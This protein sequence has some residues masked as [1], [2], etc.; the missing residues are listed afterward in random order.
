M[1]ELKRVKIQSILESQ[2]PEFLNEESPLFKSF[3]ESYYLSQEYPTGISDLAAN[4]S[5]FKNIS[6]YNDNTFFSAFYPSVLTQK[7][8]AF[9]DEINV[10]HTIGFPEKYGLIKIGDEIITYTSKT[11]N[12]FIGCYRGFSGIHD[13]KK[14]LSSTINF[15]KT[16]ASEHVPTFLIL[17]VSR[18]NLTWRISLVDPVSVAVGEVITFLDPTNPEDVPY[19]ASVTNV[20]SSQL[21]EVETPYNIESKKVLLKTIV[22]ENLSLVFYQE[23]FKKFKAQFLP[24]FEN[25]NFVPQVKIRN[26]L[27][28]ANDFYITKGTDTSF[29]LLFK[30]LYNKD[31]SVIKP[32]EYLLR[33]SDNNYFV[34]RNIL[35]EQ[36]TDGDP[37]EARGKTLFQ[38]LS[39]GIVA[40][41]SIYSIEYRPFNNKNLY[42]IYL[43][44][45]SFDNNYISTKKTNISKS[46]SAGSDSIFVDSTIGFPQSGKL[47]IK[48]KNLT[49]PI[50]INYEDKTN[51]Q[52]LGVS[53]IIANLDFNDE[54]YEENFVYC[55]LDDGS[56]LEFRLINIIGD[57]D[58]DNTSNM[59]VDDKIKLSSFGIEISDQPEFN[60]WIYN[61]PTVHRIKNV[62]LSGSTTGDVWTVELYDNVKFFIGETIQL[63]NSEDPDDIIR[64]AEI[65][66][67]LSEN[68][69][70]VYSPFSLST[71]KD[72]HRIIKTATNNNEWD[73]S[74][75]PIGI[76]NTYI[77]S[78]NNNF[79]VTSSGIPNYKIFAKEQK[80]NVTPGLGI[81]KTDILNTDI[82]HKFY[83]GEK[84]Y[85]VPT[86]L[87][88]IST[89]IY[90]LTTVGDVEDSKQIKLSLS[91]SDLYT[92]KYLN[93][94]KGNNTGFFVKLDYENK[95][96]KNQK[97][98]KK[99]NYKKNQ[100]NLNDSGDK[101]TNNKK[102]GI[103]V[104]GVEL[105]SPTLFDENIYY[106]KLDLIIVTDNGT[107]YD[108]I[109]PP[110]IE[111]S[112]VSGSGAKAYPIISG[113]L[114]RVRIINPGIGYQVKPKITV[115]G[116]NG[117][118]AVVEPNFVR[119]QIVS[120]F[121]GDG[122]GVNPTT[123]TLTFFNNHNFDDGEPVIYNANFNSNIFPLKDNAIYYVGVVNE[124][125]LRLYE[126]VENA[127]SKENQI[128]LVGISSGFHYLKSVKSKN[129]ITKLTIKNKGEGYS[130]RFV[131]VP[132]ILSFDNATNG[133]NSFDNYIFA[134]NHKF[135]NKDIV[136]YST[137]GTT[138][139]G[140]STS[141]NY[142]VTTIDENKF[143]VSFA[144]TTTSID[145]SDFT[146]K[147][148][149]KFDSL[150]SGEHIFSYPPIQLNIETLSGVGATT[151]ISPEFELVFTGSI[152]NVFLEDSGVGYGVSNII[153]FHRRPDIRIKPIASEALL[154][155]IVVNGSIV[156][157]QF[158]TYGKGYDKGI[159]IEVY[160]KGKF[161][162]IRPIVDQLGRITA[163]NIANGGVGYEQ[164]D[165][166]LKVV[167]RGINAKFLGN[168]FE[169]KINQVEKNKGLSLSQ[170]E[171]VI[172][173]SLS[174][175]LGL[176]YI[177]FYSPKAFR[178]TINDHIDSSNRE[179]SNNTHSPIIGWA[180]DG[181]PI[182]GPYG[183]VGADIRRIRSSYYKNVETNKSLRPDFDDGFFVQDYIFDK[184]I[185]DLDEYNGRYCKTPEYPNG[186]YAYFA[187][188]NTAAISK[189]E[190]PYIVGEEF[191][192]VVIQENIT[193]SFSQD[194][195]ISNK[196][197]IRNIG[198]YYINSSYSRYDLI[199]STDEK[200]KQEFIVSQ[201]LKSSVEDILVYSPGKDYKV[202]DDVIFDNN[203][204]GG[205]GI[206]A[207]VSK[208]RG[209]EI[210]N[211][212]VG[213][214]TFSEV[215]F[216]TSGSNVVGICDR[217]HNFNV[218]DDV[219]ISSISNPK[220]S[221]FE[222]IKKIITKEKTVG[223]TSDIDI[224]A[225][226]GETTNIFVNDYTGFEV[227]DYI[228]IGSEV[229][230]ITNIDQSNFKFTVNRLENT[231]IH[232]VGIDSVKLLPK[233]FYFVE[234]NL[235]TYV[236]PN[237][238]AYFNPKTLIGF[239]T[240]PAVYNL[241]SVESVNV[242]E[243]SI[244]IPNHS[245]YTGQ[246]VTYNVGIGGTGIIVS[247]TPNVANS[248]VL[249][250]N[251]TLYVINKGKNFIGISTLGFT[252]TTGIGSTLNSLYIY[253]DV[254]VTGFAHSLSTTFPEVYGKVENYSLELITSENH[255]LNNNSR[256]NFNILPKLTETIYIRY[257]S[258]LRK[259]TTEILN[260]DTTVSVSTETSRIYLPNNKFN[261]GDKVV[262][263]DNGNGSIGGLNNNQPYYVI[264]QDPDYIRLSN[265]FSD[266][267]NGIGITFTSQG[268]S[269]NGLALINPL[270]YGTKGNILIFDLSDISLSGMDLKLYKDGNISVQIESYKYKRNGIDA[271]SLGAKL[272]LDTNDPEFSNTL[273]YNLIPLSPS[274][275]EK[276]QV[277]ID[278]EVLGY[279]KISLQESNLNDEYRI[280]KTSDN[281]F[282]FNLRK[283]PER[284]TYDSNVGLSSIY[285]ETDDKNATGPISKIKLN[286][287]GKNYKKV[288][289]IVNIRSESGTGG[290]LKCIS[291]KIG[292]INYIERVK[293]G[294]DYP[295]DKTLKPVLSVPTICQI[296]GISRLDKVKVI[297]GG[298]KY[299]IPPKLKVIGNDDVIL[300]PIIQG[301]SIS[302][303]IIEKNT[304]N[305]SRPLPI[306]PIKNS[307][308]YDIDDITYNPATKDVT[309]ELINSDNQLYPLITNQFGS[310]SIDFPFKVG[311]KIFVENCRITDT[312]KLNYNSSNYGYRFFTVTGISTSNF[313]VTYNM[314]GF[315]S[316]LGEYNTDFNYGSVV[317]K[318]DM[319]E[320]EMILVDDL[321]YNS[322]EVVIG[323]NQDGVETFSARVM[324]NGWDNSI[325]QLRLNDSKGELKVGD[326]LS[327]TRSGLNG[328]VE[329]IN[330]FNL[331]ANLDVSREKINSFGDRVGFLNDYQQRISDNDY[332]QK[333]SYSIKSDVN[334][335]TWK[336]AIKSLVHPAGFK[337]FSDLDV[338]QKAS[339]NMKVGVGDS[340]LNTSVNID[341]Y[342]SMYS[343]SNFSMVLEDDQLEDGSIERVFF[344]EGVNLKSYLLSK[345]NKVLRIDDISDQFTGFTTTMGGSIVGISTFKLKNKG[346]PLFYREFSGIST[347]VVNLT[348]N[349]FNL[350]NHNFQSG[351]KLFYGV[352]IQTND[353]SA[354]ANNIVDASFSYPS[355]STSFDS[356][357]LSFDST[358]DTM[359]SN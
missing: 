2:I 153:N 113:S 134:L 240:Q 225:V 295:T 227:D 102:V 202:G 52:F 200:Y 138:I 84:I 258:V 282:K 43:D 39:S 16:S 333:F 129:T 193:P 15:S 345:T 211:I 199:E 212:N 127:Y 234:Q 310:S 353:L 167:R 55:Y 332:Y 288:P 312:T 277:S 30:V 195:D 135:K 128:N 32:Q 50:V 74:D 8:L 21:I 259:S 254:S 356:Q 44:S 264:K 109:N 178:Y 160:G 260:F 119:S 143:Y 176:Q 63:S 4:L 207:A 144:G 13:I 64:Q 26:I 122:L 10:L 278:K 334:Y 121:K 142:I 79:Y 1:S 301:N 346:I 132:S 17:N 124:K 320:F 281:I 292:K 115:I 318:K 106:G 306:I 66:E 203:G 174:I 300:T 220:Y 210:S 337:E 96:L 87:S 51:T 305:L 179:I 208:I 175:D 272:E 95:I 20:L 237:T 53:G 73:L 117:T 294:F 156:D 97:V 86:S 42:E 161:A 157:V 72:L 338:I 19:N 181:N 296:R 45:T 120:G 219:I 159:D 349:T 85:Y 243:K 191:K 116:G 286:F 256:V 11:N 263:Y 248:Y 344:P 198:P 319:A 91:K 98:F 357:V 241:S 148:Y 287:G 276:Y 151:N 313:T 246:K 351:Q 265:Y 352:G 358:N 354:K 196:N 239:G 54:I 62:F 231:G 242:P 328:V 147:R 268:S 112:D 285:Y 255:G 307:N 140:L 77:D 80:I 250:D 22:V 125:Q 235:E 355:L 331:T 173:P 170:D 187:T 224:F 323:Y 192:D 152:D 89:G 75:I 279:N 111:I 108:I 261:T 330:Q 34:T 69:I 101:S 48:N 302:K 359:D 150:G 327:G 94:D 217:P 229:L 67:I 252:T 104:N 262:Y 343:I 267:K 321:S 340:S 314:S 164:K 236:K 5:N 213:I 25:R 336:E 348:N 266:S 71:K 273:F 70:Q 130:N 46:V 230:K 297:N 184:A 65:R 103:L 324:E 186:V 29:K 194:I 83:T 290:V 183:Q 126:S 206:S 24:G 341:N 3:L 136:K 270:I 78:S 205:S 59:K 238:I 137:T 245:F 82:V 284:T 99:F 18:T 329:S 49:T 190:Y 131:K 38:D 280:T 110:E 76:Q 141:A 149:V 166:I 226:T 244:Y 251:Q 9:D 315:A 221:A 269:T 185:G 47:L 209:K 223:L 215:K 57:I 68:K 339:N 58:Y 154:K 274:V 107:G 247:E 309:L 283:K 325:N 56:K 168:V 40:S 303:V 326:V 88:G 228:G 291:S 222:G 188:I 347:S 61:V 317:N 60:C 31:V 93:F 105:Y 28:R 316:D 271:G 14:P 216:Y 232:T 201:T 180:Y 6:T 92:K 162:D 123:D 311:D 155:P 23:L 7:L 350:T 298:V 90:H 293:D 163:V 197:L 100:N 12:K 118:G 322:N 37:F 177:N 204:S 289:I 145:E 36:I 165:T 233:K 35:V 299:N 342:G 27:S 171:G 189:P 257:D 218:G 335:D 308:G 253:D 172:V 304:N 114:E 41:A 133:V 275:P 146:N 139:S 249:N 81:G 33:P 158:L 182:Y 169:W 214:S